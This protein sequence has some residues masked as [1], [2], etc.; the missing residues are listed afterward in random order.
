MT[1]PVRTTRADYPHFLSISTRWSDN[2]VYGHVNNVVYYS[3]FDTVV[4]EYLLRAGVLDFTEGETIG[5]VVETRCNF[6]ASVVFPQRIDA[7]LRVEKLGNTSVRYEVAIFAEDSDQAAAQG[8]FVHVY[9]DRETRR[10]VPLPAP[11]VDA[12]K[13]LVNA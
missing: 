11:L 13:P 1:K 12:L 6:F 8:H 9:V 5:L 7:G 3:Y 2:D 4:N 10:P